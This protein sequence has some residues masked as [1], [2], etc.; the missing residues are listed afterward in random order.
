MNL[1][2]NTITYDACK[3]FSLSMTYIVIRFSVVVFSVTFVCSH[4]TCPL[5]KVHFYKTYMYIL[6]FSGFKSFR[7][8]IVV[9]NT[10][11]DVR[12]INVLTQTN[13]KIFIKLLFCFFF[14]LPVIIKMFYR[15]YFL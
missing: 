1:N 5:F 8:G 9:G 14:K 2:K 3:C 12:T 15:I 6:Y 11:Y 7:W 4:N 13:G 10:L